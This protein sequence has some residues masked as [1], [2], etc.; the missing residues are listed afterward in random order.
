MTENN[1]NA[2]RRLSF[3]A[4]LLVFVLFFVLCCGSLSVT[5]G[6]SLSVSRE[7]EVYN[8]AVTLCRSEAERFRSGGL[9]EDGAVLYFDA[10]FSPCAE[11]EG[12]FALHVS[13]E[14]AAAA[15]GRM[16]TATL[17]AGAAGEEPVYSLTVSAYR[18]QEG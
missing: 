4:P 17:S 5:F 6:R 13:K 7:A 3:M 15:A 10:S 12:V 1:E 16:E 8:A 18:R 11:T 9:P 14:T 2:V